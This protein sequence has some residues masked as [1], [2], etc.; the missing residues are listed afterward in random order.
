MK[1]S[2]SLRRLIGVMMSA[3]MVLVLADLVV[4]A[5]SIRSISRTV[6][7][8]MQTVQTGGNR[9]CPGHPVLGKFGPR[10]ITC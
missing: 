8:D 4:G 5:W 9:Q 2:H 3:L 7:V 1:L 6:E 10:S